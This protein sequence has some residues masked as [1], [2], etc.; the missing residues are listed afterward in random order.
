MYDPDKYTFKKLGKRIQAV[1][2]SIQNDREI[3]SWGKKQLE[4]ELQ[5]YEIGNKRNFYKDKVYNNSSKL[6]DVMGSKKIL[7]ERDK[8]YLNKALF[9]KFGV[10]GDRGNLSYNRWNRRQNKVLAHYGDKVATR[11]EQLKTLVWKKNY[12]KNVKPKAD[13]IVKQNRIREAKERV[14][15]LAT[16]RKHREIRRLEKEVIR[17]V[18]KENEYPPLSKKIQKEFYEIQIKK[19][20]ELSDKQKRN[21]CVELFKHYRLFGDVSKLNYGRWGRLRNKMLAFY[22]DSYSK[23]M[24]DNALKSSKEYEKAHEDKFIEY[25]KKYKKKS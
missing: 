6:I 19:S 24:Y 4:D 7:H 18:N 20:S 22:G 12:L 8:R 5:K 1:F 2:D 21:K 14:I 10:F 3:D 16:Q 15:R 23:E 17:K 9:E 13:L 11:A 25:R